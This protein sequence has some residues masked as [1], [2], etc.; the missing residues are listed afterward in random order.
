M[1]AAVT[2]D[3]T[4]TALRCAK[5]HVA[6]CLSSDGREAKRQSTTKKLLAVKIMLVIGN[7]FNYSVATFTEQARLR[8]GKPPPNRVWLAFISQG[9]GTT[10]LLIG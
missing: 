3:I 6:L 4:L 8:E 7:T 2:P 10:Q 1:A 5:T 9:N